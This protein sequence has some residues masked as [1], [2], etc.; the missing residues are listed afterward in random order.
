MAFVTLTES[1][2]FCAVQKH[3]ICH[4]IQ[5]VFQPQPKDAGSIIGFGELPKLDC[6]LEEDAILIN[7]TEM[8][9]LACTV[10]HSLLK[11]LPAL[12]KLLWQFF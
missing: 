7:G 11:H 8:H 4:G 3:A 1:P 6:L 2:V 5:F 12:V 10:Y 9:Q